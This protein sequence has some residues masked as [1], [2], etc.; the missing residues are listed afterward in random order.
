ME[1]K[2]KSKTGGGQTLTSSKA[3]TS[4]FPTRIT[5]KVSIPTCPFPPSLPQAHSPRGAWHRGACVTVGSK[6]RSPRACVH[7]RSATWGRG[8][9]SLMELNG[10]QEEEGSGWAARTQPPPPD[11]TRYPAHLIGRVT[12]P[13]GDQDSG[14]FVSLSLK[15]NV[16]SQNDTAP[17][18]PQ[19]WG[20]CSDTEVSSCSRSTHLV[21]K[22]GF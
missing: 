11:R 15:K 22:A 20:S 3:S 8:P 1:S 5:E 19:C 2:F 10:V 14:C 9:D 6:P 4:E 7:R 18:H 13:S 21:V 12:K 16:A 17:S